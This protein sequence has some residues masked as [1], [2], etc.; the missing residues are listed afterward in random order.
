MGL[1]E[2]AE[3]LGEYRTR[4]DAGQ[5][6]KIKPKH[7]DRV[8]SKLESKRR[9]LAS[10]LDAEERDSE[11]ARLERKIAK[12]DDLIGQATWLRDQL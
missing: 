9:S 12:A 2:V 8:I 7:V 11:R 5:V 1:S 6:S 3:K 4:L 10:S